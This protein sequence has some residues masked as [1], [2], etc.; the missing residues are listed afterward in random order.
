MFPIQKKRLK[1]GFRQKPWL[2]KGLLKSARKKNQLYQQFLCSPS[3]ARERQYKNFRNKFNHFMKITKR[4]YYEK[5]LDKYESN[6][7]YTWQIL[8]EVINKCKNKANCLPS[9]FKVS[10]GKISDPAKIAEG[11]CEYFT[12]LGPTLAEK[13][14]DSINTFASY[15][16]TALEFVVKG[17]RKRGRPRKS[18]K[19]QVEKGSRSVGLKKEDALNRARWRVGS[20]EIAARV[21]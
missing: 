4:S 16:T 2:T 17:K 8:D 20:G 9:T 7:K 15:V 5:K 12:N 13:I 10:D 21:G 14:P 19:M 1:I 6:A 18:W 11:F 3:P